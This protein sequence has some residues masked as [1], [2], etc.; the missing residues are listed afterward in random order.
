MVVLSALF[1]DFPAETNHFVE[2]GIFGRY[3]EGVPPVFAEPRPLQEF[4]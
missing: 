3:P 2:P 1:T 4:L